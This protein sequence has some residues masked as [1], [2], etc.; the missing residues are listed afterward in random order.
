[1]FSRTHPGFMPWWIGHHRRRGCDVH[2]GVGTVSGQ[3][4]GYRFSFGDDDEAGFG[5]GG[6]PHG[7]RRPLRFL[8]HKLDLD[9]DQMSELAAILD[10]LKTERA[11]AA[12]EHRRSVSAL[13]DAVAGATFDA[14]RVAEAGDRRAKTAERLRAAVAKAL[15]RLHAMLDEAQRKKLSYFLRTGVVSM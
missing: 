2:V 4:G 3:V 15:E 7:V 14:A 8:A 12:V 5:F 6:G 11:Q 10:E 1:M 13:A 9:D